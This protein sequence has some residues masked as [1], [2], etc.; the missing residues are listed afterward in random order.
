LFLVHATNLL[1]TNLQKLQKYTHWITS[2]Y[3]HLL[4]CQYFSEHKLNFHKFI[5]TF[6]VTNHSWAQL[7]M[8]SFCGSCIMVTGQKLYTHTSYHH[9]GPVYHTANAYATKCLLFNTSLCHT[10]FQDMMMWWPM[11]DK[12]TEIFKLGWIKSVL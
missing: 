4:L 2:K 10:K 8:P 5:E 9:C 12:H 3:S 11:E 7:Y 6:T 1:F